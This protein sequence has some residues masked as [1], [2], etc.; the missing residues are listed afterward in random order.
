MSS[1]LVWNPVLLYLGGIS[2]TVF[3]GFRK[4][5]WSFHIEDGV[6]L[7]PNILNIFIR[8]H[9]IWFK[10]FLSS[11]ILLKEIS[12]IWYSLTSFG[13]FLLSKFGSSV[14][15]L[16][17]SKDINSHFQQKLQFYFLW[18]ILFIAKAISWTIFWVSHKFTH[19]SD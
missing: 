5:Y 11:E 4:V 13:F 16:I 7:S 17:F 9:F 3:L 15:N 1:G 19:M 14:S 6:P 12:S 18:T 8:W 10:V 2:K